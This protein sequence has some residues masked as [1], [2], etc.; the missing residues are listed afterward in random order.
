MD[1]IFA[2][3]SEVFDGHLLRPPTQWDERELGLT[4]WLMR[5]QRVTCHDRG[6]MK[7]ASFGS[8]NFRLVTF[9]DRRANEGNV[10][11][12]ASPPTER[13]FQMTAW[14]IFDGLNDGRDRW[15]NHR[16]EPM[17]EGA[18]SSWGNVFDERD[19]ST[20]FSPFTEDGL[21]EENRWTG[22][23]RRVGERRREGGLGWANLRADFYQR[24]FNRIKTD[25]RSIKK[26]TLSSNPDLGLTLSAPTALTNSV[27]PLCLATA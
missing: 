25:N 16:T 11:W 17:D 26:S 15:A 1:G 27:E 21:W 18:E 5:I 6:T 8:M 12:T 22:D 2:S 4:S 24:A 10:N 7:W 3:L 20:A 9:D 14:P 19:W 23:E 13:D